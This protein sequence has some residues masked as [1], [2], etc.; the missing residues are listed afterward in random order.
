MHYNIKPENILFSQ[1]FIKINDF[2]YSKFHLYN[3]V[4]EIPPED[5]FYLPRFQ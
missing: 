4:S 3:N 2:G 1:G 5:Y